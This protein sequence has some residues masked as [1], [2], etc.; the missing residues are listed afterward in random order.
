MNSK[1]NSKK[2]FWP[3]GIILGFVAIIAACVATIVISLDY[4]VYMDDY[5][6]TSSSEVDRNIN[7]IEESQARFDEKFSITLVNRAISQ[8]ENAN[9]KAVVR[10]KDGL[11]LA[12]LEGEILLT[13]PDSSKFDRNLAFK[14]ED[15]F[16][17]S[18]GFV[19]D[20]PG[21]WQVMIKL[22][23]GKDTG[24]YKFELVAL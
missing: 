4:P 24:F 6:F 5:Y 19:V 21:R 12:N 17:L 18:E 3:Y 16:L 11:N 15:E 22:T 8:G 10:S 7:D 2:T 1:E 20:K 23:D 9:V 14:F 13:R